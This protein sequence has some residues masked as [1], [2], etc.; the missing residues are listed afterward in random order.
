[1]ADSQSDCIIIHTPEANVAWTWG[2]H[3]DW[4]QETLRLCLS[5]R[6]STL[7]QR[8]VQIRR[9]RSQSVRLQNFVRPFLPWK[10]GNF[11]DTDVRQGRALLNMTISTFKAI[12][13][14]MIWDEFAFWANSQILCILRS[15]ER[16]KPKS[17]QCR[18]NLMFSHHIFCNFLETTIRVMWFDILAFWEAKVDG[19]LQKQP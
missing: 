17:N 3:I 1:M 15:C 19:C 10:G 9:N 4:T 18:S 8:K 7:C 14:S 13:S 12:S 11:A 16:L 6:C 5:S 2:K